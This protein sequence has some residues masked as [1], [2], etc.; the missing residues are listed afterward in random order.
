MK[1]KLRKRFQQK[2]N[3]KT[4]QQDERKIQQKEII[5]STSLTLFILSF[6][7]FR[8]KSINC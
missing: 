8:V 6:A 3:G 1:N 2:Q 4:S 7:L 5:T